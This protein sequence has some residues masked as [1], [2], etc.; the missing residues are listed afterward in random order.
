MTSY[1]A[2][3]GS[4]TEKLYRPIRLQFTKNGEKVKIFRVTKEIAVRYNAYAQ[5]N[6]VTATEDDEFLESFLGI[7]DGTIVASIISAHCLKCSRD[8]AYDS[9]GHTDA[10]GAEHQMRTC[11]CGLNGEGEDAGFN[12]VYALMWDTV[13]EKR[14]PLDNHYRKVAVTDEVIYY[15]DQSQDTYRITARI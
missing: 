5:Q 3:Y 12:C 4:V 15:D 10:I 2:V 6:D 7:T 1:L 14:Y 11:D 8:N 9:A 13:P